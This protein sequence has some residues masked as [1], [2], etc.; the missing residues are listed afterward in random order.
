MVLRVADLRAQAPR[1]IVFGGKSELHEGAFDG[2]VL[3]VIIVDCEVARQYSRDLT[4]ETVAAELGLANVEA[5]QGAIRGN[6]RLQEFG[7]GPLLD[8]HALKRELWDDSRFSLF[9]RV[10]NE[11]GLTPNKKL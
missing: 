1:R 8:A 5:L 6:P 7:L 9:H 3:V 2:G 11:F 10:A 4:P